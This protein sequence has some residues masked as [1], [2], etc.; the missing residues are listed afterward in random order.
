MVTSEKPQPIPQLEVP[1][2][3]PAL[4]EAKAQAAEWVL[5][6]E[7]M[8]CT[9]RALFNLSEGSSNKRRESQCGIPRKF[10]VRSCSSLQVSC[11]I[12]MTFSKSQ[13]L[14][15]ASFPHL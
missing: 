4:G 14:L 9:G 7:D 6:F 5:V 3:S 8:S 12:C 15:W 1:V 11:R 10:N 2:K 13:G